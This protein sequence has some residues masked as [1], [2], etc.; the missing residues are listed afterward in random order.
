[1]FDRAP[2]PP[3]KISAYAPEENDEFGAYEKLDKKLERQLKRRSR[4][5]LKIGATALT[6]ATIGSAYWADVHTNRAERAASEVSINIVGEALYKTNSDK[7]TI[8]IDGFNTYDADYLAETVGPAVQQVADGEIWSLS[9]N[10]A[11]LSREKIYETISEMVE[12]RGIE[13]V[14]ISG[15]SMGGIL[16]IEAASDIVAKSTT[17]VNSVVMMHTPDG[18]DGLRSYQ[19]KELGFAQTLADWSPSA[20]D[21]TWVRFASELYFYKN[22]YTR[23]EYINGDISYNANI[24]FKNSERFGRTFN[25]ILKKMNKP[26][27]TSMQLLSEQVFKINEF[28]MLDELKRISEQQDTKQVPTLLYVAMEDKND[29]LVKNK[30]TSKNFRT[31]SAETDIDYFSYLVPDATHSQYYKSIEEYA[32]VFERAS[33]PVAETVN[34][35]AAR[36]ALFLTAQQESSIQAQQ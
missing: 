23:G 20:I 30:F 17:E 8:F 28:D 22:N 36:H 4:L 35:E 21:S 13:S 2:T 31:Y 27:R 33:G 1:M 16:A 9:Y 7:A 5:P 11:I 15:Y 12:D 10:N 19:R 34:A 3:D 25:S 18:S 29:A 14:S 6:F 32:R 24:V 26:K